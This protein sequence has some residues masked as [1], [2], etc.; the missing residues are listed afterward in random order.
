MKITFNYIRNK[1]RKHSK[2]ELLKHCYDQLDK[3]RSVTNPI[4]LIFLLMKWT[5]LYGGESSVSTPLN[6]T[7]FN[8]ILWSISKYNNQNINR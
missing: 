8:K 2:E 5:Y 7:L 4:W 6:K 3:H 1:I